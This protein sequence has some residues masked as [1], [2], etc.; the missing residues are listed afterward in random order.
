LVWWNCEKVYLRGLCF[1]AIIS[2]TWY[3]AGSFDGLLKRN[4]AALK[5]LREQLA[6]FKA[7][8]FSTPFPSP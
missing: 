4:E 1:A 6:R 7:N 3:E 8:P 5:Y 2:L